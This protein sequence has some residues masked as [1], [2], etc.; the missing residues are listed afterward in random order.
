M[1]GILLA[2]LERY[3]NER[4]GD[5][6]WTAL[7][8]EAGVGGREYAA[9]ETYPD[10]DLMAI[11]G[12]VPAITPVPLSTLVEDFG[13]FLA[14]DLWDHF[15]HHARP[16]W[17]TLEVL[18]NLGAIHGAVGASLFGSG[19]GTIHG[20]RTGEAE[21]TLVY[22]SPRRLC[23]L[24]KGITRGLAARFGDKVEI[25][26]RACMLRGAPTCELSVRRLG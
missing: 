19:P 20:A 22:A 9:A 2:T 5:S 4:Y 10:S 7:L 18:E 24:L 11:V 6:S 21:A 25:A 13:R 26:E 1:E 17:R 16:E 23:A 12:A 14:A 15:G 8:D 3:V